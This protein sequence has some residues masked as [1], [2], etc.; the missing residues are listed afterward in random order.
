MSE[1]FEETVERIAAAWFQDTG[2]EH[3]FVPLNWEK[4]HPEDKAFARYTVAFVL[5]RAGQ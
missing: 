5:A 4:G 2:P 3:D 1:T